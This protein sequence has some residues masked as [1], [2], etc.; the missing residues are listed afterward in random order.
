MPEPLISASCVQ[1]VGEPEVLVSCWQPLYIQLKFPPN[2]FKIL[3]VSFCFSPSP[4]NFLSG[5]SCQPGAGSRQRQAVLFPWKRQ[6][7]EGTDSPYQGNGNQ[8][9][10]SLSWL[11]SW[12]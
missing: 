2:T 12:A 11:L 3:K 8:R 10:A 9:P 7:L 6:S 4:P 5:T 1:A